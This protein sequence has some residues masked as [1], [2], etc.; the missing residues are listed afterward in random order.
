MARNWIY[1]LL[2]KNFDCGCCVNSQNDLVDAMK[3]HNIHN[4]YVG[5]MSCL[6]RHGLNTGTVHC[7]LV[8][9]SYQDRLSVESSVVCV[10]ASTVL[11]TQ[12]HQ[13]SRTSRH[14]PGHLVQRIIEV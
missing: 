12:C 10:V 1:F 11:H 4:I 3:Q 6:L 5:R 9:D 14:L 13:L 7:G 8:I 2:S